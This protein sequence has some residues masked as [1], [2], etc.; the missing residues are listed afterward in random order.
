MG[1]E[2][3]LSQTLEEKSVFFENVLTSSTSGE[4]KGSF[5]KFIPT[6]SLMTNWEKKGI[7]T[8]WGYGEKIVPPC[9]NPGMN[10]KKRNYVFL[11]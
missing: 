2:F 8:F 1:R 4:K 9:G 10:G 11:I 6:F 5:I 7:G 3:P